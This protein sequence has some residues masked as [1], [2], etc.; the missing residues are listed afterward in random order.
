MLSLFYLK[1]HNSLTI[2]IL[3]IKNLNNLNKIDKGTFLEVYLYY[4]GFVNQVSFVPS[5]LKFF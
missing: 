3:Q 1:I 4:R 2:N 5:I